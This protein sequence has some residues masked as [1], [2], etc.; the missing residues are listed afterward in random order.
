[1]SYLD[2]FFDK[3]IGQ[4]SDDTYMG[5]PGGWNRYES[6]EGL[7]AGCCMKLRPIRETP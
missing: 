5:Q 7:G 6:D 4:P 3:F 2:L 1:M